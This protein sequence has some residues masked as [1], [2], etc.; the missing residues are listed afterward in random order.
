M[1]VQEEKCDRD[2]IVQ[3]I[4]MQLIWDF[5]EIPILLLKLTFNFIDEHSGDVNTLV[6]GLK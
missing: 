2:E 6:N 3:L 5:L 1:F 4:Y